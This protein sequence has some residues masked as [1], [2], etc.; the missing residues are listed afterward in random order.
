MAITTDH[1]ATGYSAEMTGSEIMYMADFTTG[2]GV[3]TAQLQVKLDDNW[4]PADTSSTA[5]MANVRITDNPSPRIF[6]WSVTR[7]SGTI[8]TVLDATHSI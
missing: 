7:T 5:T 1:T 2:S 4:F 8:R 6:R 3:G